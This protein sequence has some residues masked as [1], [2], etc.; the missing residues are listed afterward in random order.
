MRW[1]RDKE[2]GALIAVGLEREDELSK[3]KKEVK[4]LRERVGFLEKVVFNF[5]F[6]MKEEVENGKV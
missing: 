2:S 1:I 5:I 4:E 3:L 6:N